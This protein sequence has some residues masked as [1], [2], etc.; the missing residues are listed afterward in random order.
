MITYD[1]ATTTYNE[2]DIS[3]DGYNVK[4][5]IVSDT[6]LVSDKT[7]K[8][9]IDTV[10]DTLN[11]SD[12]AFKTLSTTIIDTL[13]ISENVSKIATFYRSA[14]DTISSNEIIKRCL[15]GITTIF[16]NKSSNVS[17]FSNKTS[18]TSSFT[19]KSSN[20]SDFTNKDKS[21]TCN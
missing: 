6:I 15:N 5:D 17:N 20:T 8:T 4:A 10:V 1:D 9:F 3:Y 19:N 12:K 18:N 7:I 11:I 21:D 13:N 14:V 16:S 2:I